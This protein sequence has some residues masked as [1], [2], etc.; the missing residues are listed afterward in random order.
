MIGKSE[1][2][3]QAVQSLLGR[4]HAGREVK[5]RAIPAIKAWKGNMNTEYGKSE[6]QV[7]SLVLKS[8]YFIDGC[9]NCNS[10]D[11]KPVQ[12]G[13]KAIQS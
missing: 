11:I 2:S 3:V 7:C 5:E 12:S 4:T 1:D 6:C 9:P 10:T 13:E 8:N